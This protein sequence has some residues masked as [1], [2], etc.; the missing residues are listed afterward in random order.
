MMIS[1]HMLSSSNA[2]SVTDFSE[3]Q[4][5]V[6][7]SR[8]GV[9]SVH[10]YIRLR[11]TSKIPLTQD[12]TITYTGTSVGNSYFVTITRKSA[13]AANLVAPFSNSDMVAIYSITSSGLVDESAQTFSSVLDVTSGGSPALGLDK[14]IVTEGDILIKGNGIVSGV[15]ASVHSNGDA[16]V[17]GNIVIEGDLDAV[18]TIT[19]DGTNYVIEG[20]IN[21]GAN[22]VSL[23]TVS[24]SDYESQAEYKLISSGPNANKIYVVATHS[25]VD[26]ITMGWEWD[27]S[28]FW[29][30]RSN[31]TPTSGF[32][33]ADAEIR[34]N[35][36]TGSAGNPAILTLVTTKD[37]EINGNAH[38]KPYADDLAIL[39]DLDLVFNG[40]AQSFVEGIY[41][42][43]EQFECNGNGDAVGALLALGKS[44]TSNK[45]IQNE[46]SGNMQF[47]GGNDLIMPPSGTNDLNISVE[48]FRKSEHSEQTTN[49][50]N[51]GLNENGKTVIQ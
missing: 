51:F 50:D 47:L 39:A 12:Q 15:Y 19:L 11:D 35:G 10:Q 26:P 36:N 16:T 25:Y 24:A 1:S 27:S 32:Y 41:I 2:N 4:Q 43:G 28:N 44:T 37:C 20:Q 34:I 46:F 40:N 21:E 30:P 9:A 17:G 18:Q 23:P 33:Y 5:A 13:T 14:A 42:A 48:Q 29:K 8:A 7:L 38:I 22:P 45:V 49:F 31:A 6:Y 3:H